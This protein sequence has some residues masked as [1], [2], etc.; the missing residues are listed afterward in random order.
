VD[1]I[2]CSIVVHKDDDEAVFRQLWSRYVDDLMEP[3]SSDLWH[4]G[5][6]KQEKKRKG[7]YH[8]GQEQG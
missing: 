6:S 7:L 1:R 8:A 4:C 5:K 3:E 2:Y